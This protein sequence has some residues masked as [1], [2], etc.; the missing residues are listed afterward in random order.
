MSCAWLQIFCG[1]PPGSMRY[2][3]DPVTDTPLAE[4][5]M[6][7]GGGAAGWSCNCAPAGAAD[8]AGDEGGAGGGAGDGPCLLPTPAAL[9]EPSRAT[10]TAVTSLLLIW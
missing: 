8:A 4:G 10:A 6:E 7:A 5:A 2:T 1:S 9:M 3:S